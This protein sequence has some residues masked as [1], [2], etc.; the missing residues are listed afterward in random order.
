MG[1]V[2]HGNGPIRVNFERHQLEL[3]LVHIYRQSN[4]FKLWRVIKIKSL[5]FFEKSRFRH[6]RQMRWR[7]LTKEKYCHDC[8]SDC[9]FCKP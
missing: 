8:T 9:D 6:N 5:M 3:W 4:S 2:N 1:F 7:Q